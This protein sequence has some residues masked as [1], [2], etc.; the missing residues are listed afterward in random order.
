MEV[1]LTNAI[2]YFFANPSHEMLYYEAV[3][4]AID[5]GA[6]KIEIKIKMNSFA[7]IDSLTIEIKDN[8]EGFTDKNFEKFNNLLDVDDESH[9][10]VGRLVFINYF[11]RVEFTSYF[12]NQVRTFEFTG[13]FK[14]ENVLK[15]AVDKSNET[16]LIF[17]NYRKEKINAYDYVK[18]EAIK[19]ALL[20][21]FFPLLYGLKV[22][23][24]ELRIQITLET[25][26][27]NLDHGFYTDTK[28]LIVSQI[29]EMVLTS[30]DAS[31]VDLFEKLDLYY[32]VKE[33]QAE[34]NPITALCVDGRTHHVDILS[35][36]GLP[37][38]YEIIFLL[39]SKLFTG[40]SNSS[41]QELNMT[42]PELKTIKKLFGEKV[43][44]ILNEQ[45]PKIQEQNKKTTES[46]AERF[47]HLVGYFDENPVGLIDRNISLENAQ[48]KFFNAQ[49]EILDST[50]LSDEQFLKSLEISSRLL[51]EYILY[52]NIIIDKLKQIDPTSSEAD[53]HNIIVPMRQTFRKGNI[54][55]DIY[56]NNAWLL[57]DKYMS[58]T[59]ILSDVDMDKVL[60][61]IL[62]EGETIKKDETRPDIALIFSSDPKVK[63]TKLDV[64]VVELKKLGVGLAKKEELISQL[65]QRAR[66][67]LA[68]YGTRIQRIW[69]YGIVDFDKEFIRSLKEEKYLEVFSND[70]YYY[71][72]LDII[73]D[74]DE[75][76]LIP[77]GVNILSFDAFLK[78]AE[79]RNS[80]FLTILK[81]GLKRNLES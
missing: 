40:K 32:S 70:Q 26:E 66:K 35:K 29:P 7:D 61:E 53:I 19:K 56:N 77:I 75:N 5:A 11:N 33:S 65:R 24:K 6:T 68:H 57:D 73:P 60:K 47:P 81:E 67:L 63:D 39:Y 80:T 62:L 76:K 71:K 15:P 20:Q 34:T 38:G 72:E 9:K 58:Y 59:T 4:N 3:A 50:S 41:R 49:K 25:K 78:D 8:G 31:G 2:K 30:F 14:G 16:I 52:R 48:L 45:I 79:V 54:I 17:K 37:F 21:H 43:T 13:G 42:E 28:E 55:K 36:G 22:E 64:V 69:F 10:G 51:T 74:Y 1:N 18:P 44:E 23:K 27:Q 12:D 46:L